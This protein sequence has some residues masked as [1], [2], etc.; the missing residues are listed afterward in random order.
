MAGGEGNWVTSTGDGA[1]ARA[2]DEDGNAAQKQCHRDL[3]PGNHDESCQHEEYHERGLRK[4]PGEQSPA[5][6]PVV[7]VHCRAPLIP[8]V[9]PDPPF[10]LGLTG[11]GPPFAVGHP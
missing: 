9:S 10:G 2:T 3:P 8:P 11:V 6:R 7:V 5:N 4:L 1:A